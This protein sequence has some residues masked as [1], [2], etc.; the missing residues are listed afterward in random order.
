MGANVDQHTNIEF[1]TIFWSTLS[2]KMACGIKSSK[3][4]T[5]LSLCWSKNKLKI[6]NKL[7]SEIDKY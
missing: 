3:Y 6:N 2:L 7:E 5:V 1:K 4:F